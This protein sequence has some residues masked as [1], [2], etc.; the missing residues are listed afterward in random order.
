MTGIRTTL[1][2]LSLAGLLAL[3]SLLLATPTWAHGVTRYDN[4]LWFDG[5]AFEP[6]TYFSIDGRLELEYAGEVDSVV[7]LQQGFVVPQLAD[8]HTHAMGD[9][10]FAQEQAG[11]LAAGIFWLPAGFQVRPEPLPAELRNRS[12]TFSPKIGAV[13]SFNCNGIFI[14]QQPLLVHHRDDHLSNKGRRHGTN[15]PW[16]S[17][18]EG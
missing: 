16:L 10:R 1:P 18:L 13:N 2:R 3:P 11:F 8:A 15:N 9:S 5:T 17:L 4:G 7:D 14:L 12:I 6:A